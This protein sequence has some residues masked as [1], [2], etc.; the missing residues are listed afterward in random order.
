MMLDCYDITKDLTN[1][2]NEA[3]KFMS[4]DAYISS[5]EYMDFFEKYSDVYPKT[6]ENK[7]LI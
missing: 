4:Q 6:I 5:K 7:N 1:F 2:I 3:K